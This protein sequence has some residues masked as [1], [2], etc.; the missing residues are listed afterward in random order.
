MHYQNLGAASSNIV[1]SAS[2]NIQSGGAIYYLHHLIFLII[3]FFSNIH[4]TFCNLYLLS[5][6]FI[7][8]GAALAMALLWAC[9]LEYGTFWT[10]ILLIIV[11]VFVQ[12]LH[13][14]H[15]W[16]KKINFWS[17][18]N[19]IFCIFHSNGVERRHEHA[20]S[21]CRKL[22]GPIKGRASKTVTTSVLVEDVWR[23]KRIMTSL[24]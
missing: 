6:L 15:S 22:E 24:R 9:I 17:K 7:F 11:H 10:C 2:R 13:S 12:K 8:L 5:F 14:V 3:Q 19:S 20:G 23:V 16:S 21:N 4:F 1:C 18:K